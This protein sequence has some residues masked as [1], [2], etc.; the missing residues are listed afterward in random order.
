VFFFFR[1]V[2]ASP[3]I[4]DMPERVDWKVCS[5]SKSQE[6]S[7]ATDFK[8]KFKKYDFTLED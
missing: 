6:A 3:G 8:S 7:M 5:V 2:L 4:L 1:E